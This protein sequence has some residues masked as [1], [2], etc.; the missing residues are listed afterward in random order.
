MKK[1]KYSLI[2]HFNYTKYSEFNNIALNYVKK[3]ITSPKPLK[4]SITLYLK[5]NY[6]P[7]TKLKSYCLLTGRVRFTIGITQT[8]RQTF[9]STCKDGLVTG[10]FFSSL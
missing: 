1:N 8:S 9:L 2:Q 4:H 10:F 7:K 6:L 3:N 5:K